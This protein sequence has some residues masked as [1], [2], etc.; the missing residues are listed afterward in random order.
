MWL[1]IVG[2]VDCPIGGNFGIVVEV[3]DSLVLMVHIEEC[4]PDGGERG[5]RRIAIDTGDRNLS[6]KLCAPGRPTS[7]EC[8][9]LG[10][11]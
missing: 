8:L 1:L 9:A 11:L 7:V 5:L 10:R 4:V 6:L 2:V 3:C